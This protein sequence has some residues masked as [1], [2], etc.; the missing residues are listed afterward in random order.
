MAEDRCDSRRGGRGSGCRPCRHRA[1]A[2]RTCGSA[3]RNPTRRHRACRA[4]ASP[5]ARLRRRSLKVGTQLV[6]AVGS[7]PPTAARP[8]VR[9]RR[10]RR[11]KAASF[12]VIAHLRLVRLAARGSTDRRNRGADRRVGRAAEADRVATRRPRH[13]R[14]FPE[15]PGR[16]RLPAER[17]LHR[18]RRSTARVPASRG[19]RPPL[20]I[21]RRASRSSRRG[22]AVRR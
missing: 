3:H 16:T 14:R 8:R 13:A 5:R 10:S 15:P 9:N 11:W 19:H 2:P 21:V 17:R 7:S 4:S 20:T 18:R 22:P 12:E 1:H 6:R